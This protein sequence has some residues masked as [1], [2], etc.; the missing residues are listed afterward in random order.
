[1]VS[2]EKDL[3]QI[4]QW[5]KD[6]KAG[7]LFNFWLHGYDHA[8]H[9][10]DGK[11]A[12]EFAFRDYADQKH[13]FDRSKELAKQ[14]FGFAFHAFGPPGAGGLPPGVPANTPPA[15]QSQ[16]IGDATF[17]CMEEDA[18]LKV[19]MYPA[20]IDKAAIAEIAKGKQTILRRV[21]A[22][23]IESPTFVANYPEFINGY[24]HNRGQDYFVLQGHPTQ[25]DDKRFENF[26]Q[27]VNFLIDQKAEFVTPEDLIQMK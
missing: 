21:F 19:V 18:D 7:G 23:N 22:V 24:A 9:V 25:W 15:F 17:K 20:P 27:I 2:F 1:M 11:L 13:R 4:C 5:V 12:T 26:T 16:P 14:R 3:P 10:V 6:K 8:S